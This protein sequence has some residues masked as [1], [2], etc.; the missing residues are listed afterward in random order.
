MAGTCADAG[1]AWRSRGRGSGGFA[2]VAAIPAFLR[3][4][5]D[6]GGIYSL[7]RREREAETLLTRLLT[8]H[9]EDAA[10]AFTLARLLIGQC[11]SSPLP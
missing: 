3:I 9:R 8:E 2:C 4:A 5:P 11:R 1:A 7:T 10:T 6:P